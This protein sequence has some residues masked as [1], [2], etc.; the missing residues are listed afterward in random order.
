MSANPAELK[1]QLRRGLREEAKRFSPAECATASARICQ[2]LT[3]QSVWK[4]AQ[5]VLFYFPMS[6]EPDIHCLFRTA[7]DAGKA[8]AFPRYSPTHQHYV[9]CQVHN[10]ERDLRPGTFGIHE[11]AAECPIFD[12]KKLDL[13]LVPGVGFALNGFRLGRGKGYYDRLLAEM[14]GFKCGVA[15]EW[16]LAVEIPAESHDICLDCILTPTRWHEVTGRRRF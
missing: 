15:F 2:R 10:L 5:S 3:E 4:R 6:D 16:Q 1:A 8:A 13:V 12:R 9:A 11:P 14:S 7:L